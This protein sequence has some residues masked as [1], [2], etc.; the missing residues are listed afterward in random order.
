MLQPILSAL[1]PLFALIGLGYALRCWKVLH[2]EHVP[3]LNGLVLDVLLPASILKALLQ[4]PALSQKLI[5]LPVLFWIGDGL[6]IAAGFL[7]GRRYGVDRKTLGAMLLVGAFG[8]T[9][10]LGYPLGQA[11]LPHQFPATVIIDQFG[12]MPMVYPIA[13]ILSAWCGAAG[14]EG[15]P[16]ALLRFARGPLFL[17][18]V[19]AIVLR[20][21]TVPVSFAH[22]PFVA[23]IV[24]Q[25]WQC[26][27][28]L[29]QATTPVVLLALGVVLQ[30][31]SDGVS[32]PLL[33]LAG[34]IKLLVLPF[35]IWALCRA[36]GVNGEMRMAAIMQGA[37]PSAVLTAVLSAQLCMDGRFAARAVFI[38]TALS[39]ITL[40]LIITLLR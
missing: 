17:S 25:V 10:F 21:I 8:N 19:V 22:L 12:M 39:A 38:T 40:P 16:A 4:A 33:F 29:S 5:V 1:M 2:H 32:N 6:I 11:L 13:I 15:I 18:I 27:I 34:L 3:V 9:A 20:Q 24:G 7:V 37:M 26:I 23:S 28:Y 14:G 35:L 31:R 30:P 36:V